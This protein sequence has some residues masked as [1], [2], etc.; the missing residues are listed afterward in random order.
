MILKPF[1]NTTHTHSH[2][3]HSCAYLIHFLCAVRLILYIVL[4]L[5][6]FVIIIIGC[7]GGVNI[8]ILMMTNALLFRHASRRVSSAAHRHAV[9]CVRGKKKILKLLS[10]GVTTSGGF[11]AERVFHT[12]NSQFTTFRFCNAY[13]TLQCTSLWA[14]HRVVCYDE[15]RTHST[16]FDFRI[17]IFVTFL[18][19]SVEY[20]GNIHNRVQTATEV[21]TTRRTIFDSF[22]RTY[23]INK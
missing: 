13:S 17:I 6:W 11:V 9:M 7:G 19:Y 2:T 5:L 14:I 3:W 15:T 21:L 4:L 8:I 20:I 23:I 12:L 1:Y 18:L 10:D 22:R 16:D